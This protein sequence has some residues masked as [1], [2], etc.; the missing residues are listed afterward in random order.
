M[1]PGGISNIAE[2]DND[3]AD[4]DDD[5]PSASAGPSFPGTPASE[6]DE[7]DVYAQ[8]STSRT[9]IE[10]TTTTVSSATKKRKAP[11]AADKKKGKGKKKKKGEGDEDDDDDYDDGEFEL[12]VTG[13]PKSRYGDRKPGSF[14]MCAECNKKVRGVSMS[15]ICRARCVGLSGSHFGS[16]V[17]HHPLHECA[18]GYRWRCPVRSVR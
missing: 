17:H 12:Q 6:R 11:A 5:L 7:G 2:D 15:T 14:A 3:E 8:A 18:P 16:A 4:D 13:T 9:T 1:T 10:I